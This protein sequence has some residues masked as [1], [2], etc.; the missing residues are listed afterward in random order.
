MTI[1][2]K[3]VDTVRTATGAL[4]YFGV[5]P[6]PSDDRPAPLPV[7]IVNRSGS[8]WP[9]VF[10]GTDDKL[11]VAEIQTDYYAETAE[12]ARRLADQ[13]RAALIALDPPPTLT[14]EFSLYDPESRAWRVI[15][16]WSM[17]DYQPSLP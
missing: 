3:V 4:T 15:Q 14:N 1:E 8:E 6:Q 16:R 5:Q 10:C 12:G 17:T 7:A 13:G 9:R 2:R 11:T